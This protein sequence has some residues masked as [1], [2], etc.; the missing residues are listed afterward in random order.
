MDSV[1]QWWA[2]YAPALFRLLLFWIFLLAWT[3][4]FNCV[5]RPSL[6][7]PGL[8]YP[9]MQ[10]D[11]LHACLPGPEVRSKSVPS[12]YSHD[13][14]LSARPACLT[15]DLVARLQSLNIHFC[16][17]RRR[18]RRGRRRKVKNV[19]VVSRPCTDH[20]RSSKSVLCHAPVLI[21]LVHLS[22]CCVTPPY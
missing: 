9:H 7:S 6:C 1:M 18:T 11:H 20:V 13:E 19:S 4:V 8:A 10:S 3:S 21:M 17:P 16:L 12:R 22:Q 2:F 14:L 15:P 5:M